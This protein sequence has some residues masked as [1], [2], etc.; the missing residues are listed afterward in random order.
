[1]K[2]LQFVTE[3]LWTDG[4]LI[5]TYRAF[6]LFRWS[7]TWVDFMNAKHRLEADSR[8]SL[9]DKLKPYGLGPYQL[10]RKAH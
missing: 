5:I 4:K 2:R 1:M 7:A 9:M 6:G 3:G 10:N 8:R